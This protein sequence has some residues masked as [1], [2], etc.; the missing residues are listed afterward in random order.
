MPDSFDSGRRMIIDPARRRSPV[1]GSARDR[2]VRDALA[3]TVSAIREQL[4]KIR[5]GDAGHFG[6]DSGD[7]HQDPVSL[8]RRLD[9]YRDIADSTAGAKPKSSVGRLG[10]STHDP[11]GNRT[12]DPARPPPERHQACEDFN[13]L[14]DLDGYL[15]RRRDEFVNLAIDHVRHAYSWVAAMSILKVD[16]EFGRAILQAKEEE[17]EQDLRRWG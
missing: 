1:R 4:P 13:L 6:I 12:P 2:P 8:R 17:Q 7:L 14:D 3:S 10:K 9:H 11:I 15:E 5:L 16:S